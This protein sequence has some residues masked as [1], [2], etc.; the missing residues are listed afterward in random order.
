MILETLSQWVPQDVWGD[1]FHHLYLNPSLILA[2]DPLSG[3]EHLHNMLIEIC[4]GHAVANVSS[5]YWVGHLLRVGET[6]GIEW[7]LFDQL[8]EHGMSPCCHLT[9]AGLSSLK[10]QAPKSYR[11]PTVQMTELQDS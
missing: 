5:E 11:Q 8:T 3:V 10:G 2:I 7:R 4:T 6:S 9:G 1:W